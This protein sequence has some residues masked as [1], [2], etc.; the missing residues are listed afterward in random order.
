MDIEEIIK[1]AKE[2]GT[3]LEINSSP[4]RLDLKDEYI[5]MA[6]SYGCKFAINSDAHSKTHYRFLEFGIAQARRGWVEA[7]DVIN[8]YPLEEMLA[9]LK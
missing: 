7:E 2:T 1:T 3:I 4:A 5:K 9:S 6:L 8:T